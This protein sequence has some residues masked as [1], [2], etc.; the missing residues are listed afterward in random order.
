MLPIVSILIGGLLVFGYFLI[1]GL[2]FGY[3]L[4]QKDKR[5][6]YYYLQP[7]LCKEDFASQMLFLFSVSF[8]GI[9]LFAINK[10]IV[11]PFSL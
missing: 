5:K 3:F 7:F 1:R 10:Q 2:I 9:A 8:F 6:Q 11:H 4:I